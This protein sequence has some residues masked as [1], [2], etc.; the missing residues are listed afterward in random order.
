MSHLTTGRRFASHSLSTM[1]VSRGLLF[2]LQFGA[3]FGFLPV[4]LNYTWGCNLSRRWLAMH[5]IQLPPCVGVITT[6]R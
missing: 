6:W 2:Y 1:C 4:V 3:L 5:I